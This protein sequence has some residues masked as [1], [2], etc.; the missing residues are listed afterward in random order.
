MPELFDGPGIAKVTAFAFSMPI[1]FWTN[2]NQSLGF[3]GRAESII[4]QICMRQGFKLPISP[5]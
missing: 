5:A 3:Q 4:R 1:Y 2:V